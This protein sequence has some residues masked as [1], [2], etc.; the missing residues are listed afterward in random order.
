[1]KSRIDDSA[2]AISVQTSHDTSRNILELLGYILADAENDISTAARDLAL[3]DAS[4]VRLRRASDRVACAQTLLKT[5]SEIAGTTADVAGTSPTVSE[6][7]GD[8]GAIA[9]AMREAVELLARGWPEDYPAGAVE[10][11]VVE[12]ERARTSQSQPSYGDS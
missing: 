1:M 9:A 2:H 12:S 7:E 11:M 10:W 6:A 3:S 8:L 4:F 5:V